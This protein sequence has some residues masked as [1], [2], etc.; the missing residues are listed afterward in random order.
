MTLVDFIEYLV[1]MTGGLLMLMGAIE[2][3]IG[4]MR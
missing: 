1:I 3:T 4:D 2:L